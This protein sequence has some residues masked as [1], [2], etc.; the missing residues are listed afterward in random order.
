[1]TKKEIAIL[2]GA[3]FVVTAGILIGIITKKS[4]PEISSFPVVVLPGGEQ[5]TPTQ[6][7]DYFKAEIPKNAVLT[8]ATVEVPAAPN[9]DSKLKIFDLKISAVGYEPTTFT[10]RKGDVVQIRVT[11]VGGDYDIDFP[12]LQL[13]QFIRVGETKIIAFGA[14]FTG[15]TDF[16]CRDFCGALEGIKGTFITIP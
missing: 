15:T 13:Y 11:S 12:Y 1:M 2:V 9:S 14:N 7:D 8:V 3:I 16:L 6:R 5:Q 4:M 10:A